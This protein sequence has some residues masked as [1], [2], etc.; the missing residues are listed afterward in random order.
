MSSKLHLAWTD[1]SGRTI[2]CNG[3]IVDAS[4][5]GFRI[6]LPKRLEVRSYVQLHATS[7]GFRG[8][9]CVRYAVRSG[10]DYAAGLEFAGGVRF[11]V[12]ELLAQSA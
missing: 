6:V 1:S 12:P 7:F 3:R 9:A 5:S 8:M 4:E 10:I 2:E 11:A